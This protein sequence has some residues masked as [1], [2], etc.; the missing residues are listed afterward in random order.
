MKVMPEVMATT[1]PAKK[2]RLPARPRAMGARA[3]HTSATAPQP[4]WK[5][6][7]MVKAV[8]TSGSPLWEPMAVAWMA[9]AASDAKAA[10]VSVTVRSRGADAGAP[11]LVGA[12]VG[13]GA[14][15]ASASASGDV[16]D[17]SMAVICGVPLS[18]SPPA[19]VDTG[20]YTCAGA[21]PERVSAHAQSA[22]PTSDAVAVVP[23]MGTAHQTQGSSAVYG[24]RLVA[25]TNGVII[26][27]VSRAVHAAA[28]PA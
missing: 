20:V 28:T 19:T 8:T 2:A 25:A 18:Y 7:V 3:G 9:P 12:G 10:M 4:S 26:T 17:V 27:V 13:D 6:A 11:L 22:R 21:P 5:A 14:T 24:E 23:T 1:Q 15:A 16:P